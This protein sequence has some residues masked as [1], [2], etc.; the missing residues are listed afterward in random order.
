M[1]VDVE[2]PDW[3]EG[4]YIYIFAGF[5]CVAIYSPIDKDGFH[6]KTTRCNM[7]GVCCRN[8]E[9]LKYEGKGK[10]ACGL[11][12]KRPFECCVDNHKNPPK[13]CVITYE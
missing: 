3:V 11:Y 7:C 6:V 13:G 2:L 9:H 4:R 5:E 12:L 10:L 1:K 8:C